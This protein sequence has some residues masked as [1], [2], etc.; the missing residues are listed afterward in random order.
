LP[1]DSGLSFFALCGNRL[2]EQNRK[3]AAIKSNLNERDIF[4]FIMPFTAY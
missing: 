4:D 3:N 2:A 1:E